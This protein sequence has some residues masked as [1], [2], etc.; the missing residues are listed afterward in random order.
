MAAKK[1]NW[2][3]PRTREKI[4][5]TQIVNRLQRFA[6]GQMEPNK[7]KQVEMTPAQVK[8]AQVL[9][10]KTLPDLSSSEIVQYEADNP[11]ELYDKLKKLLGE[12]IAVKAFPDMEEKYGLRH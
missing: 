1:R 12:E 2:V 11:K 3:D 10:N 5:T 4:R 8:A 9:I 7:T 6:L